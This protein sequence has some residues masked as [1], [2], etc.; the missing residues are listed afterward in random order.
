MSPLVL[1]AWLSLEK[2]ELEPKSTPRR[3]SRLYGLEFLSSSP[4]IGI[5]DLTER[6]DKGED[7]LLTEEASS[8][9][10]MEIALDDDVGHPVLW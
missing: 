8:G 2:T 4:H 1:V 9:G 10:S 6:M 5:R 7:M 3:Q